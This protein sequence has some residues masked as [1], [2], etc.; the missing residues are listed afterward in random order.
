[1]AIRRFSQSGR[2]I[3]R[4][5]PLCHCGQSSLSAIPSVDPTVG[6]RQ[7]EISNELRYAGAFFDEYP[8]VTTGLYYFNQYINNSENHSLFGG[9]VRQ[10]GGGIQNHDVYVLGVFMNGDYAVTKWLPGP[11]SNQRP[12]D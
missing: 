12:S 9:A 7:D 11:D 2:L 4:D 8:V 1:M 5:V 3:C 10:C 6:A